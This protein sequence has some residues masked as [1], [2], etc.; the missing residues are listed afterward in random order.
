MAIS[1][2]DHVKRDRAADD[3]Q[4]S[5]AGIG[6]MRRGDS[7]AYYLT[8]PK[9]SGAIQKRVCEALDGIVKELHSSGKT[10]GK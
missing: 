4:W 8:L 2:S 7:Y 6:I 10:E 9:G 5:A 1:A 3:V